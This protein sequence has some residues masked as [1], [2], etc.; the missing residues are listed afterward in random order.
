MARGKHLSLEEAR[1]LK[2]GLKQFAMEHDS[3]GDETET[4]KPLSDNQS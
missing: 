4:F 1:Q 3:L 2:D